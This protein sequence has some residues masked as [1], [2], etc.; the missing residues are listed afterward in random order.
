VK[1]AYKIA[2]FPECF[3][4][5]IK[6]I[7]VFFKKEYL[8]ENKAKIKKFLFAFNYF[9]SMMLEREKIQTKSEK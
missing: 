3:K 5:N 9:K 2:L 8:N 4:A 7:I 6:I 1:N